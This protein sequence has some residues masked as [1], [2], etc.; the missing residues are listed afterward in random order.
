MERPHT[1]AVAGDGL[2]TAADRAEALA[3]EMPQEDCPVQHLFGPGIYMRVV[4]IKAGTFSIGHRQTTVH[5]NIMLKGVV[6]MFNEDGTRG[7]LL[8]APVQFVGQPGRKVGLILEDMAWMNVYATDE[9]DIEKLEA[10][11]LDKSEA[12]KRADSARHLRLTARR[13]ADRL[14]YFLMLDEAGI[15]H[16][17]ALAQSRNEADQTP[18]PPGYAVRV[19]ASPIEGLGLFATSGFRPGDIIAPARVAG[20]R[21][22]AGRYTN[23]S[24][25]PNAYMRRHGADIDLVALRPI[26]GCKGGEPGDEITI[27]YRQALALS[28]P[29][30]EAA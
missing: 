25:E 1:M 9:T 19:M 20:Y 18:M 24:A 7:E 22:P 16:S 4:T 29:E 27:D 11:Y 2:L 23:H 26:A 21:T 8:R 17:T 3:L 10:T 13:E 5:Q 15:S 14:D 28:V 12:W 6:Q 30:L